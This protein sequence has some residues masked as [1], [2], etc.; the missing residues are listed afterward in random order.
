M[1]KC[2]QR[3]ADLAVKV[4]RSAARSG[5]VPLLQY[6]H[7]SGFSIPGRAVDSAM[8]HGNLDAL[9]WLL[10]HGCELDMASADDSAAYGKN[11]ELMR[12]LHEEKGLQYDE[13]T[14][15]AA[16]DGGNLEVMKYFLLEHGCMLTIDVWFHAVGRDDLSLADLNYLLQHTEADQLIEELYESMIRSGG[17]HN[18]G[19]ISGTCW[20]DQALR[21]QKIKW[22]HETAHCPWIPFHI[23]CEALAPYARVR[24][25]P[26]VLL[27]YLEQQG[28]SFS[29]EQLTELLARTGLQPFER[30]V[31]FEHTHDPIPSARWL[32]DH[33][34][35]WP[36]E[37]GYRRPGANR[38]HPW[39][40][41]M[42][43]WA[44]SQGCTS[45][46]VAVAEDSLG[47]FEESDVLPTDHDD[48][49]D[50]DDDENDEHDGDVENK[51]A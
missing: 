35:L 31:G 42:V 37:Q 18:P 8:M 14:M 38:T 27:N 49:D 25:E 26:L 30:Q 21:L 13:A 23:A 11:V 33:G 32:R 12:W 24:V 51:E 48:D 34:A 4:M 22:L 19:Q 41:R 15:I 43:N 46:A 1:L 7:D 9:K 10:A 5:N 2:L 44:A 47:Y 29:A 16:A 6:L 20:F 36:D 40:D 45:A 39:C 3:H 17:N 50:D 28:I